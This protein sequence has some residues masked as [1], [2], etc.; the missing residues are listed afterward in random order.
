MMIA[1]WIAIGLSLLLVWSA[2]SRLS[3]VE[4]KLEELRRDRAIRTADEE[5]AKESINGLRKLVAQ[6]AAGRE[7][8]PTMVIENRLF[9]DV[10]T[11]E[12]Q[13]RVEAGDS[14][15]VVD[16]RTPQEW[17]GGRIEGA[18]HVP[19]DEVQTRLH[20]IPRDGRA[21][22]VICAAGGRSASAADFLAN[23][24]YLNVFNVQGGM[25]QWRGQTVKG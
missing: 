2:R 7:V 13:E 10:T 22:Y 8:D 6:M 21:M 1:F 5:E 3:A 15:C 16:V 20:E 11:A 4:Q 18:L 9:R 14:L 23:R 25:G 24:G 12:L 19:V 17:A